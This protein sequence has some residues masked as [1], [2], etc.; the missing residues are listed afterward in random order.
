MSDNDF[1]KQASIAAM[2]AIIS[3]DR[4]LLPT[5][6]AGQAVIRAKALLDEIKKNNYSI[7][8][9]TLKDYIDAIDIAHGAYEQNL[10]E[11]INQLEYTVQNLI[12]IIEKNSFPNWINKSIHES[13]IV[14]K[15]GK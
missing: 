5:Q 15:K 3:I 8:E 1:I 4:P 6:I 10:T 7:E 9:N 13:K 11:R 12:N 14:P 2:Q